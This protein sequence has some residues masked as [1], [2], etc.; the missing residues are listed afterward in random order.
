MPVRQ[1]ELVAPRVKPTQELEE[2]P[3]GDEGDANLCA[4]RV[5]SRDDDA[6]N[7]HS[8]RVGAAATCRSAHVCCTYFAGL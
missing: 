6:C 8:A 3:K 4:R 5:S 7:E 1:L 2:D